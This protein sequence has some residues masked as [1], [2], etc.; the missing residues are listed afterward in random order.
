MLRNIRIVLFLLGEFACRAIHAIVKEYIL[1]Q[2][3]SPVQFCEEWVV[4]VHGDGWMDEW[5]E[6]NLVN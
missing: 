4:H 2:A 6:L 5:E 1:K 3:S